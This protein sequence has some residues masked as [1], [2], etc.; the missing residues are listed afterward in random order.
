MECILESHGVRRSR[1]KEVKSKISFFITA[2]M[3]YGSKIQIGS[4]M[5]LLN[6]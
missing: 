1:K 2:S 3:I 6:L 4:A 5:I